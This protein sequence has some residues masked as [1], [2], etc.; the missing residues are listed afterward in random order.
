MH[1]KL[2]SRTRYPCSGGAASNGTVAPSLI[3]NYS[4]PSPRQVARTTCA[5]VVARDLLHLSDTTSSLSARS[6]QSSNAGAESESEPP[7]HRH[8]HRRS[9]VQQVMT[10]LNCIFFLVNY[11]F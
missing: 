9:H 1:S 3:F 6:N 7:R 10:T 8:K 5:A 11:Y 2:D 4:A